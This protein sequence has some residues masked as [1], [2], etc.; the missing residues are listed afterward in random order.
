MNERLFRPAALK[1]LVAPERLD[2]LLHSARPRTWVA[3]LALCLV[4]AAAVVWGFYGSL[5]TVVSGRGILIRDGGVSDIHTFGEGLV[6]DLPRFQVGQPV[7]KNQVLGHIAQPV[8]E[9]AIAEQEMLLERIAVEISAA[10][11]GALALEASP[12]HAG[13]LAV[14]RS[15][16]VEA[17]AGLRRLRLEHRLASTI[18][19]LFDG[20]AVEMMAYQGDVVRKG[21][22][23][24]SVEVNHGALEAMLYLPPQSNAKLIK[25]GMRAQVSPA[26][27]RKERFG[28]LV[29]SVST[30]AKFPS[31]E[32]GMKATFDNPGLIREMTSEG[33]PIAVQVTLL[34][35]PATRSGY[36]WSSRSGAQV[37]LS[38]GTLVTGTV[39]IEN[40]R[41]V[42]LV[43]PM[44]RQGLGL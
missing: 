16:Q 11:A 9:Q 44:L 18:V 7:L 29:G 25:P 14:L 6:I 12:A 42:S 23:V 8:L 4:L 17:Q 27:S 43:V 5:P 26:T 24:L 20:I 41:P 13:V 2:Q 31:T 21:Q 32:Q 34:P 38:S 36:R 10:N 15:R 30:V 28:Y 22:S 33:P 35:D 39:V 40:R 19:S 3:L 37:E 1:A